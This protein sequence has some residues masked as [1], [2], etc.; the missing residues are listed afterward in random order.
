MALTT[1]HMGRTTLL[2]S[3]DISEDILWHSTIIIIINFLSNLQDKLVYTSSM[4][5]VFFSKPKKCQTWAF[6]IFNFLK[7][8]ICVNGGIFDVTVY[9]TFSD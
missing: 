8:R 3:A 7:L 4:H 5:A 6:L 9:L 1:P 2:E